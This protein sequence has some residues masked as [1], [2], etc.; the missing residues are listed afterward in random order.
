MLQVNCSGTPYEIGHQHGTAANDK[1]AGSLD[2]YKWLF[3]TTCDMDWPAVRIEAQKYVEPLQKLC[4]RYVEEIRGVADG[5]GVEFIDIVA[6]NVRTEITFGLFTDSPSIPVQTDGCTSLAYRQKNGNMLLAQNWD[7]RV[8]QTP[9][10]FICHITQ[11]GTD[12]P[13]ISFVTEGGVIGKIG[14]NTFGVGVSLN[15]IRARGLDTTK[16]PIHLS[17]R[18]ALESNSARDAAHKL[19]ATGTAGSGHILVSDPKEAIGLECTSVGIKEIKLDQDGTIVHAN[20]LMLDH[21]GVDERPPYLDSFAR[22]KR[23]SQLV[24]EKAASETITSSSLF[25]LFKDEQGFPGSINRC[26]VG[27]SESQTLFNIVMDLAERKANVYFGRPTSWT[28]RVEL[29][30]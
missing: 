11:P 28:E 8:Q 30:K 6:L 5:A 13:D 4:P 14:F 17:L 16:L 10:L 12:L 24:T 7:W 18:A 15:A 3:Q 26:Q 21:P 2:F 29:S 23:L 20:H 27:D 22:V 1:V 9:N 19:Q 25:E